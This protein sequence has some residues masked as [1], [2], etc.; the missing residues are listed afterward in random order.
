MPGGSV[1]TQRLSIGASSLINCLVLFIV[2]NARSV[3]T[4]GTTIGT[5]NVA[6]GRPQD[7]VVNL[8]GC[9]PPG[10][11]DLR[12]TYLD[13]YYLTMSSVYAEVDS[14]RYESMDIPLSNPELSTYL[15]T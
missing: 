15:K 10:M 14:V 5:N 13:S 1:F 2:P 12:A 4:V 7:M 3:N 9:Q 8:A 6:V 11:G